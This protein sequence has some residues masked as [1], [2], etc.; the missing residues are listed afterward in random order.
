MKNIAKDT[1]I[2]GAMKLTATYANVKTV[3]GRSKSWLEKLQFLPIRQRVTLIHPIHQHQ[4]E[5]NKNWSNLNLKTTMM[6]KNWNRAHAVLYARIKKNLDWDLTH[7]A[8][9][10]HIGSCVC[11]WCTL[12]LLIRF[13]HHSQHH[14]SIR[15][16][17][18]CKQVANSRSF[19][20]F[21]LTVLQMSVSWMILPVTLSLSSWESWKCY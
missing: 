13:T 20:D 18:M 10:L 16:Q 21:G 15:T 12:H 2:H 7:V 14:Q 3:I 19:T 11:L 17:K 4:M 5:K 6:I 8:S 1:K 9:G